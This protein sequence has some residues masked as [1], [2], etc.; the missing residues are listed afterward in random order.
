MIELDFIMYI[1]TRMYINALI[2]QSPPTTITGINI[3]LTRVLH[4]NNLSSQL[5]K[6]E[7]DFMYEEYMQ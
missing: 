2:N 4:Q 3:V 6:L 1:C 7:E 5:Y